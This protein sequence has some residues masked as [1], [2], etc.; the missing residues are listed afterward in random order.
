MLNITDLATKFSPPPSRPT[1]PSELPDRG[2]GTA[3]TNAIL[4]VLLWAKHMYP[5]ADRMRDGGKTLA[6][7]RTLE[8]FDIHSESH[9]DRMDA[10]VAAAWLISD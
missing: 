2:D 5:R 7:I 9:P 4:D 1:K 3:T 8:D 10:T 6:A